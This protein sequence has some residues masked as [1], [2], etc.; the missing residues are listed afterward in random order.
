MKLTLIALIAL[1]STMTFAKDMS[2]NEDYD[3]VFIEQGDGS[4]KYI[5]GCG[6][7]PDYEGKYFTVE[8]T[9]VE[10]FEPQ[11]DDSATVLEKLKNVEKELL[12]RA[13]EGSDETTVEGFFG[14]VDDFTLEKIKSTQF[15]NLD[16]YRFNIGVGGGN[17]YFEYYARSVVNG[18]VQY[19]TLANIFDGDVNFCDIKVWINK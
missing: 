19:E 9:L 3:S 2:R 18:K 16:L 8:K 15:K 17:G 4:T 14:S 7:Y 10:Y 6:V 5:G 12:F 1:T 13:M 11:F